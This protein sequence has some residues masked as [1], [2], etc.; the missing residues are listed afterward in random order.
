[1]NEL[2]RRLPAPVRVDVA[3]LEVLASSENLRSC[4]FD[5]TDEGDKPDGGGSAGQHGLCAKEAERF[6][7]SSQGRWAL[8]RSRASVAVGGRACSAEDGDFKQC[9][10]TLHFAPIERGARLERGEAGS[11]IRAQQ[12]IRPVRAGYG[13][14]AALAGALV[15]AAAKVKPRCFCLWMVN[16]LS[17]RGVVKCHCLAYVHLSQGPSR[18]LTS[19]QRKR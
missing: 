1:M 7:R 6:A 8:N 17:R 16:A 3:R 4:Q 18:W 5:G 15:R 19:T 11:R 12:G 13:T 9:R 14:L 2:S 10:L